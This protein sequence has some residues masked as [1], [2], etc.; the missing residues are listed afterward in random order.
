[1]KQDPWLC[2]DQIGKIPD[3][4][5]ALD[6]FMCPD[7]A[8]MADKQCPENKVCGGPL[9]NTI[10]R[11]VDM[12]EWRCTDTCNDGDTP[13]FGRPSFP[14]NA[15]LEHRLNVAAG[16]TGTDRWCVK[17]DA[18]F[19]QLAVAVGGRG[20]PSP[21]DKVSDWYCDE[22]LDPVPTGMDVPGR[23]SSDCK[24]SSCFSTGPGPFFIDTRPGHTVLDTQTSPGST[25]NLPAVPTNPGT[26]NWG[27]QEIVPPGN[28]PTR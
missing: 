28:D 27:N 1:M 19:T 18:P 3:D 26:L 6:Q 24:W 7:M 11:C 8:D 12:V 15:W 10:G 14:L 17:K 4:I 13:A 9:E 22:Q 20:G 25:Q 2:E 23:R 5:M 16:T 21:G